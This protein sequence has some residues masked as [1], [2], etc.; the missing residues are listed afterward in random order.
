M[1][2]V[3]FQLILMPIYGS[4]GRN[5]PQLPYMTVPANNHKQPPGIF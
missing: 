3:I 5:Q 1:V 4:A 2:I